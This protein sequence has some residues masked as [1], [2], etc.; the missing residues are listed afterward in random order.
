MSRLDDLLEAANWPQLE[1]ALKIADAEIDRLTA[2]N[3]RLR[4]EVERLLG[5]ECDTYAAAREAY[6]ET[7]SK[8]AA[9]NARLREALKEHACKCDVKCVDCWEGFREAVKPEIVNCAHYRARAALK[10]DSNDKA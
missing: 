6:Q 3:A 7:I 5:G 8:Q 9:E 2:E 1:A 4:A 10:E